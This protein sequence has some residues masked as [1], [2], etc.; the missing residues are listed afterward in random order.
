[1]LALQTKEDILIS[2]LALAWLIYDEQSLVVGK[3]TKGCSFHVVFG[4]R[5]KDVN[6][7]ELN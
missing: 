7:D 3:L 2:N 4:V 6:A 1:M 5:I